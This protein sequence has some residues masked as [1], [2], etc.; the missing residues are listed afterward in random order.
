[1]DANFALAHNQLAQAY[2]GKHMYDEAVAE[3]R[4]RSSFQRVADVHSTWL[5]PMLHPARERGVKTAERSEEALNR[6]FE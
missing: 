4:K 3:F 1:M 2:L 5:A 6:S